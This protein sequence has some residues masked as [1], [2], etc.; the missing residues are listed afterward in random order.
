MRKKKEHML[1][2]ETARQRVLGVLFKHPDKEFSLSDLAREAE[3]AKAN[4]GNIINEFRKKEY[5]EITELTKIWRIRANSG[6]RNF[7]G[8]KIASNLSRV[9]QTKI[10][11]TLLEHFKNPKAIILIGSFRKGEDITNSDIDIA[12]ESEKSGD[13]TLVL[14]KK[15]LTGELKKTIENIEKT[16]SRKIQ[17]L[18]FSRK[19]IDMNLFKNIANGIVLWGFLDVK[20]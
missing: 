20:P 19:T 10:I 5:I 8:L 4:I 6:N 2:E 1:Y 16:L 15:M 3:V 11:D 14:D 17:I 12:I 9:Y 18:L 13:E 7:K